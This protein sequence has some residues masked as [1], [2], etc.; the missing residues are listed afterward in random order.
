VKGKI[1]MVMNAPRE[2]KRNKKK[3]ENQNY[4]YSNHRNVLSNSF[5]LIA[6][7]HELHQLLIAEIKLRHRIQQ[8]R[9]LFFGDLAAQIKISRIFL[10]KVVC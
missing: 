4:F 2:M 3:T 1:K 8:V 5:I 10:L 6:F 7:L 9:Q